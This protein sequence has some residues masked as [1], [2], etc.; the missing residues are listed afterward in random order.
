MKCHAFAVCGVL[1]AGAPAAYAQALPDNNIDCSSLKKQPDGNWLTS[2][3]QDFKI[4][5][6]MFGTPAEMEI[7]PHLASLDGHDLH[8]TIEAKCGTTSK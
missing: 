6:S 7:S 2:K 8:A 3:P 4:G 1:L 5:T